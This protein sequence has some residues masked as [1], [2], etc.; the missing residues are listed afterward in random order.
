MVLRN[1]Q[2]SLETMA[3]DSVI[4]QQL[5]VVPRVV[6]V[7]SGFGGLNVARALGDK[8]VEV[9]VVDRNNYHG[10]WPLLYQVAT[11]GLEQDSIA[12]PVRAMLRRYHNVSFQMAEVK[13]VNYEKQELLTDGEPISYDYL[14]ISAGSTSNF[15]G[16]ATLEA[17][18]FSLKDVEE[19]IVLRNNILTAFE[20]AA[21]ESDLTRR[22]ALLTFVMIGGG[23]T[24]VELSGAI[25]ELI[26]HVMRKDYPMLDIA[27]ARIVLIESHK[28]V[29]PTFPE[30]LRQ[31]ARN[32]LIEMGVELQLGKLVVS[33]ENGL[34]KTNDGMQIE[35]ETVVWAAGVRG[36]HLGEQLGV[37]LARGSRVP[38]EPTLNLPDHKNVFVIGDLAYLEG[39]NSRKKKASEPAEAYPMVAQV[40]IQMGKQTAHNILA[41][42]YHQPMSQFHYFDKGN[43]ATI[44]RKS[45]VVDAFGVRISGF[46]AWVSWL[47][48]HIYY[49]IG[50]R[51]RLVVLT[52][53]AYNY[54]TYDRASRVIAGQRKRMP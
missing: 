54:F 4:P 23:P 39:F 14:V 3:L 18:T 7:G 29:L 10:F 40:A 51:N 17:N 34:V 33:V 19:A 49:L 46:L 13:G 48:V 21:R 25:A 53:W 6:V 16:N 41:Q 47:F 36:A 37:K 32:R 20:Q 28:Y 2:N 24:G 9:V 22:K 31:S 11:A 43:M 30:H 5:H 27:E 50:F 44:G 1:G 52:N 38:I 8:E 45:A 35:A 15:F 42:L 26:R 12:Y